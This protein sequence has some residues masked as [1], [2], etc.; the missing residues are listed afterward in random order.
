MT[1]F[2]NAFSYNSVYC[3]LFYV[4]SIVYT[5]LYNVTFYY[6]FHTDVYIYS[7]YYLGLNENK[8]KLHVIQNMKW[9]DVYIF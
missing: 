4:Q 3:I 6:K 9:S 1:G 5:L 2:S 8:N 7:I